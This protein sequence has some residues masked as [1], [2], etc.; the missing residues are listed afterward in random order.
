ML[1]KKKI[2]VVPEARNMNVAILTPPPMRKK[3][4]YIE[5][6]SHTAEKLFV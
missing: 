1:K 2:T 3:H 4:T 5:L 6:D